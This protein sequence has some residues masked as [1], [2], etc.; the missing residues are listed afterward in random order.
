[1]NCL[2]AYH[3]DVGIRKN[4][5]QDS[6]AVNVLDT[7]EGRAVLAVVCDGM[8]GLSAGELAS[9]E[10]ITT[11]CHWFDTSFT[12][13]VTAGT[14]DGNTVLKEWKALAV[15]ENSRLGI[16]GSKKQAGLGTTLSALLL[17][18][19]QYFIV[20]VG[21]SRIYELK[22]S[23][24]RQVTQDQS[25]VAKEIAEGKLTEQEALRD[26]RRSIL[27]QCIGASAAVDAAVYQGNVLPGTSYVVCSDGF[28]HEITREEMML[29]LGPEACT[30]PT[31]MRQNCMYLTDLAKRRN[32]QDNISLILLK[33]Y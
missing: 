3:T 24:L 14:F 28:C 15:S 1:M 12:A 2:I 26:P 18:R 20:H 30:D 11:Y 9:K 31:V 33:T 4:T 21:D 17:Y 27:L 13:A 6:L 5:N 25:V 23:G 7:P 16:Y 29:Q 8:G 22:A 19:D 32:E 10:V